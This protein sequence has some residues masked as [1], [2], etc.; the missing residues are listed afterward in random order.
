MRAGWY[1][2]APAWRLIERVAAASDTLSF[3]GALETGNTH[4][5]CRQGR[6]TL[7]FATN[8]Y[9]AL[10]E[11][12]E[13]RQAAAMAALQ[14]GVSTGASRV[15]A[16]ELELHLDLERALADFL[17]VESTLTLVNGNATNVTIIGSCSVERMS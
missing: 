13:V 6:P 4:R 9:L 11:A 1:Q 7:N 14:F 17:G 16:G 12:P 3:T 15:N 8:D 10:G 2:Q 5:L